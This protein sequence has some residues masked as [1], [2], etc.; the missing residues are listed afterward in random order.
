MVYLQISQLGGSSDETWRGQ[1]KGNCDSAMKVLD[2]VS[3]R[4]TYRQN[5]LWVVHKI[6]AQWLP[7][8]CKMNRPARAISQD[9][10]VCARNICQVLDM[11]P[12]VDI[13]STCKG[14]QKLESASPSVDMLPFGMTIPVT[15][16]YRSEPPEELWITLYIPSSLQ[17]NTIVGI[18]KILC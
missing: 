12:T 7:V 18:A 6:P 16:P 15:V 14:E 1:K 2:H 11:S 3:H 9:C 5:N 8:N 17:C 13:S 10:R 4:T